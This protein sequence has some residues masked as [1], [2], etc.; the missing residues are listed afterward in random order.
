MVKC[1]GG[2]ARVR[3]KCVKSNMN[4]IDLISGWLLII[5]GLVWGILGI[6][7]F[8]DKPFNLVSFIFRIPILENIIYLLVGLSAIY[9]IYRIIGGF[10]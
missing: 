10:R 1:K 2:Y 6:T 3:D 8:F 5:G 7:G 4:F 9:F